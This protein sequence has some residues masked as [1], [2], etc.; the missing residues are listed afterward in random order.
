MSRS[1]LIKKIPN[2][3]FAITTL[4][5]FSFAPYASAFPA[6]PAPITTKSLPASGEVIESVGCD[7]ANGAKRQ[8]YEPYI[9][10][11]NT[12]LQRVARDNL[13]FHPQ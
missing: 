4:A 12:I 8:L 9:D 6:P 1:I 11:Q 7:A 10:Q 2:V 13:L 3:R 5:P